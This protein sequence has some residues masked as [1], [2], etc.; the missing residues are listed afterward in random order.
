MYKLDEILDEL[1]ADGTIID[2]QAP[3]VTQEKRDAYDAKAE[4]AR[5]YDQTKNHREYL[6]E[7]RMNLGAAGIGRSFFSYNIYPQWFPDTAR[8]FVPRLTA[9]WN[10]K[11]QEGKLSTTLLPS[12]VLTGKKFVGKSSFAVWACSEA[13]ANCYV[14]RNLDLVPIT[15]RWISAGMLCDL[16]R[17]RREDASPYRR[18]DLLVVDDVKPIS[19]DWARRE[20]ENLLMSRY[21]R[22]SSTVLTSRHECFFKG[23][24][25]EAELV[26]ILPDS[27]EHVLDRRRGF[28]EVRF[29]H[30]L[31]ERQATPIEQE[32][33]EEPEQ[34][35][36]WDK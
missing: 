36:W 31:D 27:L 19:P 12:I 30:E 20:F 14:Q 29:M 10:A 32:L 25:G 35:G 3:D 17:N 6:A 34:E 11:A 4:S 22:G 16:I 33:L 28:G 21:W 15:I 23:N 8:N 7:R 9:A 18:C 24:D 1:K 2:F 13:Y 5:L 26:S